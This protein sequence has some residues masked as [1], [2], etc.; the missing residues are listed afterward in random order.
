MTP[1][2]DIRRLRVFLKRGGVIAYP[3][4]SC[5][6]LG[7]DPANRRAVQ[8]ILRLKRRPQ[9]KG[10]ILIGADIRQFKRYL[11]TIPDDIA[12]RLN[13]W[14]PGP[15]TLLLPASRHCPRWLTGGHDTLA[16]RI[17]AHPVCSH[18]CSALDMA[19]VSTSANRAGMRPIK[20]AKTCG[21]VFGKQVLTLRGQ[22]GQR[23][24]PSR[25]IDPRSG[26]TFRA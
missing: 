4:E 5:Y 17:S 26:K 9:S 23:K 1:L 15:N 14:W 25:I 21:K 7:C 8:R 24:R 11:A 6:G 20:D 2:P 18:L 12:A 16:V 22:I 19:L 10:L 3:T 13:E